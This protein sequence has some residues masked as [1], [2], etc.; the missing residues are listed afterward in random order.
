MERIDRLQEEVARIA[1]LLGD[2]A[3]SRGLPGTP[4]DHGAH[5]DGRGDHAGQVRAPVRDYHIGPRSF[6]PQNRAIHRQRAKAVRHML[7]QRR[8][9]EQYFPADLFADPAWAML[10]DLYSARLERH[11]VAVL[12]LFIAAAL[13]GT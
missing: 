8:L 9:R 7:R 6:E 4:V 3:G 5:G 2:L 13:P 12:T 10:P 1:R 11:P